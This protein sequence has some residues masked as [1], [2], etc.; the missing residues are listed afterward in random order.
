MPLGAVAIGDTFVMYASRA[1]GNR[2]QHFSSSTALLQTG[3]VG[4]LTGEAC[5]PYFAACVGAGSE[6]DASVFKETSSALRNHQALHEL[7]LGRALESIGG[8][9]TLLLA[10]SPIPWNHVRGQLKL[11]EQGFAFTGTGLSPIIVSFARHVTECRLLNT[12]DGGTVL[13]LSLEGNRGAAHGGHRTRL[14]QCSAVPWHR[15]RPR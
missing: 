3:E 13:F 2:E 5:V 8:D 12:V 10:A 6:F 11:F 9:T 15:G 7:G 14:Q 4:L 1:C